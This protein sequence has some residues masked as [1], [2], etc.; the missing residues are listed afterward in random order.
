MNE[1]LTF[2]N[3]LDDDS[4][5]SLFSGYEEPQDTSSPEDNKEEED[6]NKESEESAEINPEEIFGE[7]E[8]VGS[9]DNKEADKDTKQNNGSSPNFYSSIASA[10]QE[11]G[12]LEGLDSDMSNVTS[13]EDFAELIQQV[14]NN[15]LDIT[16]KRISDALEAKVEPTVIKQY[17]DILSYL[18]TL[19]NDAIS[20]N[21]DEAENLRKNLIYR[22]L[23]NRGYT[24][25]QA[26]QK[27]Q[28]SLD[29][30]TDVEDAIDALLSNKDY[31]ES[32]YKK[33]IE[34]S[35]EKVKKSQEEEQ[36]R[37]ESLK[38]SILEDEKFYGDISIDKNTRRKIYDN[39]AKPTY[40]DPDSGKLLTEVQKYQLK[41][42][43]E[44]IKN[45]GLLYTLTDGFKSLDKLVKPQVNKQIKKGLKNLE[46]T[47][48]S[49][50][51]DSDGNLKFVRGNDDTN[52]YFSKGWSLDI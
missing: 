39:I 28:R 21:T 9:E 12:I 17:E 27:V 4:V 43:D 33:E 8:S 36:Q 25:K 32:A 44:F 23:L 50:S 42:P 5:E 34:T 20:A 24:E 3:I 18:N 52:S 30:G 46:N 31:Y 47:I 37:L 19:N 48:N 49:T 38:K 6:N 40:K 45:V 7:S 22:D 1:E 11:D 35:N 51:R 13:A 15:R 41:N 16:Q 14:V 2:D 26:V 29:A 10:L